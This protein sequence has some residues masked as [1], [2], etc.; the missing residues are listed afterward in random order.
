MQ[1]I[2][3]PMVDKQWI[4]GKTMS[5]KIKIGAK[6][7]F[8]MQPLKELLSINWKT[9]HSRPKKDKNVKLL[10]YFKFRFQENLVGKN[11]MG[12]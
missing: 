2:M 11:D 3:K 5:R 6:S 7:I 1:A 4:W 12:K 10:I 9:I 8:V